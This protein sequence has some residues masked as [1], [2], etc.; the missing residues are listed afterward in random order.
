MKDMFV[1]ALHAM[2]V[3]AREFNGLSFEHHVASLNEI[4]NE[5]LENDVW[6]NALR[7]QF[8]Q[9]LAHFFKSCRCL[10]ADNLNGRFA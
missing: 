1:A 2:F 9:S 8:V 3:R 5:R 4:V 7:Q 6:R 10:F